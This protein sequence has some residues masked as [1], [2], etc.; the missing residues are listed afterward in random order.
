MVVEAPRL[1]QEAW[2]GEG[3]GVPTERVLLAG[4]AAAVLLG[5]VAVAVQVQAVQ[6]VLVR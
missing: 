3:E 1:E 6:A 5:V 4:V 2:E